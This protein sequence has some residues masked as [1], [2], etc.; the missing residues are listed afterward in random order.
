MR[1]LKIHSTY[2]K[3]WAIGSCLA[4]SFFVTSCDVPKP[5]QSDSKPSVRKDTAKDSD[6]DS[7]DK[8]KDFAS[9]TK[10]LAA[11]QAIGAQ[12]G[13]AVELLG[14]AIEISPKQAAEWVATLPPGLNKDACLE[15]VFNNW[16]QN[17]PKDAAQFAK[18]HLKGVDYRLALAS[19]V[20]GAASSSPDTAVTLLAGENEPLLRGVLID[21][22]VSGAIDKNSDFLAEWAAALPPGNDR[23]KAIS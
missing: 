9:I 11:L 20:E 18:T 5:D 1:S 12:S 21:S 8:P 13:E 15:I 14:A 19:V 22:L 6:D 23:D 17:A 16:A 2:L 10:S 3:T 7:S 4:A